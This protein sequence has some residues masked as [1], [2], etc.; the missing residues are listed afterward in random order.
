MCL[1]RV[2]TSTF[3]GCSAWYFRLPQGQALKKTLRWQ[4]K[5]AVPDLCTSVSEMLKKSLWV[6]LRSL[7]VYWRKNPEIN[8]KFRKQV[9]GLRS[10]ITLEAS[11]RWE[12]ILLKE[13]L[14]LPIQPICTHEQPFRVQAEKYRSFG[15]YPP[16]VMWRD[17]NIFY[18][19]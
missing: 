17:S 12:L 1:C 15:S 8:I 2:D 16:S 3:T 18:L 7:F 11:R 6:D 4:R 5:G 9:L 10:A 14:N 13:Y 19:V